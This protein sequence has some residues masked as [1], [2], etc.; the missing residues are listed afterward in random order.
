MDTG[1]DDQRQRTVFV[2]NLMSIW[3]GNE[4]LFSDRPHRRLLSCT[5]TPSKAGYQ[6]S[7]TI[8][9]ALSA[10]RIYA[11]TLFNHI[12]WNTRWV[13]DQELPDNLVVVQRRV[14]ALML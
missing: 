9:E 4:N 2:S 3:C 6:S 11:T 5:I 1:K 12:P 10:F 7:V 13:F 14:D 8:V